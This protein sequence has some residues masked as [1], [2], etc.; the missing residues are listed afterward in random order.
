MSVTITKLSHSLGAVVGGVDLSQPMSDAV[1]EKVT[2]AWHEH[3][4]LVFRDQHL[5][6][7]QYVAFGTRFGELERHLHQANDYLNPEHPE[8]YS[9]TNREMNG[10]P[11]ETRDV[12]REWH[13]D[14]SYTVRPLKATMLYCKQIPESGGDTM[15]TNL[16][17]AYE[18][19]SP[20]LQ[21]MLEDL[22]AV[23]DFSKR[24]GNLATYLDSEK[25][26]ERRK[27]SPPVEHPVGRVHPETGRRALYVSKAVT[28]RFRGMTPAESEG[29]L[30]YLFEHSVRPELTLRHRWQVNDVGIWDNRCTLH[31]ALKDFDDASPRHML[32]MAVLGAVSGTIAQ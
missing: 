25:I 4:L 15:F 1:F 21:S 12:G 13:T 24:L 32:R 27:S 14:K 5:N 16:Y 17:R 10:K 8:I 19:L 22:W 2:Q 29:L 11:S 9:I 30:A 31:L 28:T 26:A 7:E 20:A 18:T 3:L 23:H 6:S